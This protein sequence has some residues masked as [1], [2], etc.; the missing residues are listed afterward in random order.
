MAAASSPRLPGIGRGRS[1]TGRHRKA[2]DALARDVRRNGRTAY[3]DA[4][5][6]AARGHA[7]SCDRLEH[8]TEASEH[9]LTLALA[10]FR[11][12]LAELRPYAT[13][14]DHA[15]DPLADALAAALRDSA[16][17]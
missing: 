5:I 6:D 3:V 7:D 10:Q 9:T 1:R 12:A 11:Y 14:A 8:D 4:L 17:S 16:A 13:E 2:L 15:T